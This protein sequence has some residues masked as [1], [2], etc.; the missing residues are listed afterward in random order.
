MITCKTRRKLISELVQVMVDDN[1]ESS[2]EGIENTN[3]TNSGII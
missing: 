1:I 3:P 2:P